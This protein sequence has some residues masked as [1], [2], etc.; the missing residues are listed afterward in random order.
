MA[1]IFRKDEEHRTAAAMQLP[2]PPPAKRSLLAD[3]PVLRGDDRLPGVQR[4]GLPQ[5]DDHPQEGRHTDAGGRA[6]GNHADTRRVQIEEPV[7]DLE[8]RRRN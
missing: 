3:Q 2:D 5:P 7:G 8:E 1:A 6:A 4:L